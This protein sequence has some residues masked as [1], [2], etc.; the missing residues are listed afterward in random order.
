MHCPKLSYE[1]RPFIIALGGLYCM[2]SISFNVYSI[3]SC[4]LLLSASALIFKFRYD[5][6]KWSEMEAIDERTENIN[7][8]RQRL[9]KRHFHNDPTFF[10]FHDEGNEKIIKIG[11]H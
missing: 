11:Q 1:A 8:T 9:H 6:R 10:D 2:T 4:L 7:K 3:T 5:N